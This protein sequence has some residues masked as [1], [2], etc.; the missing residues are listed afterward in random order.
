MDV[1]T[2]HQSLTQRSSS[3]RI[4]FSLFRMTEYLPQVNCPYCDVS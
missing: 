3:G 4:A 2:F 1:T